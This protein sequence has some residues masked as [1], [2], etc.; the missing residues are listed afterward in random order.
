MRSSSEGAYSQRCI[1]ASATSQSFLE[2]Q[3]V[4]R[5]QSMDVSLTTNSETSLNNTLSPASFTDDDYNIPYKCPM[6]FTGQQ[7]LDVHAGEARSSTQGATNQARRYCRRQE[8]ISQ[9]ALSD[10]SG[11]SRGSPVKEDDLLPS[12]SNCQVGL[13]TFEKCTIFIKQRIFRGC[14]GTIKIIISLFSFP[15]VGLPSNT[16]H[17]SEVM[18]NKLIIYRFKSTLNYCFFALCQRVYTSAVFTA[19]LMHCP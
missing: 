7:T 15:W 16:Y 1:P 2:P 13:V 10:S 18:H 11:S 19:R 6:N 9:E 4:T 14:F 5:V 17:V 8:V 3:H 12:Q